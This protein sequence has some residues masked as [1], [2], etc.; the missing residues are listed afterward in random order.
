[1]SKCQREH[2]NGTVLGGECL[3]CCRAPE[4]T[5]P[6]PLQMPMNFGGKRDGAGRKKKAREDSR[7]AEEGT[8]A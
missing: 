7:Q 3:L 5:T 1:M 2:C 6:E 4:G 8:A